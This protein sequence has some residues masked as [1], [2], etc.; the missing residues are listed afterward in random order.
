LSVVPAKAGTHQPLA[1]MIAEDICFI[2]ET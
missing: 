1:L 2:A